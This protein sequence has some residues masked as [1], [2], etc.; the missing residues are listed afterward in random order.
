VINAPP[1]ASVVVGGVRGLGLGSTSVRNTIIAGNS[2][3]GFDPDVTGSFASQGHNLIGIL[4]SNATGFVA[5]DLTGTAASPLDPR[6]GPL[7]NNGGPTFTH[8]LRGNS[9]A[10]NAG[11]NDNAPPTDQRGQ[12]RIVGGTIDIG[13]FEAQD[14]DD[15]QGDSSGGHSTALVGSPA[16]K[17]MW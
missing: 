2:A 13:A 7:K 14:D 17:S 8:A 5:S 1:T 16:K 15:D 10:L 4:T 3:D 6:L 12:A 9:P 11:D